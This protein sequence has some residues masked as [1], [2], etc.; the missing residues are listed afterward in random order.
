MRLFSIFLAISFCSGYA[1]A[2]QASNDVPDYKARQ[3]PSYYLQ[4]VLQDLPLSW[5][6]AVAPNNELWISHR[7]GNISRVKQTAKESDSAKYDVQML[8]FAPD[9]LLIGGQGGLLDIIFHPDYAES[10]WVYVSYSAGTNSANSLKIV[11]FKVI[12]NQV[13]QIENVFAVANKKNTPVH[14]GGRL[15]FAQ[16]NALLVATGDGFDYRE[17]AQVKDNQMGK[18]LR[19]TDTG[20][21][22]PLNP[23]FADG[24]GNAAYVMSLGHR[25]P[26]GLLVTSDQT[27]IAHEHGPAGGDEIN[28]IESGVNYGW[29]VI[30][31]GKDY[32]GASISPFTSY[33]GMQQPNLDWTPSIAPSG[34]TYY[35]DISVPGLQNTLLISS[36]KFQQ[37]Y[38]VPFVNGVFG[39]DTGLLTEPKAR[40]RDIESDLAGNVWVLGDGEP[41]ELF[42]LQAK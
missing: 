5:A 14:Y 13:T 28:I 27:V 9:D 37:I 25:N 39:Q 29:P 12:D 4:S 11:R 42:K 10:P 16:G 15:A 7:H 38:A 23:F 32:S 17:Q 1:S 33:A 24:N 3:A 30:T 26:Q 31:N 19:M 18:V 21:P 22:H 35:T 40:L 34:M 2:Q 20:L 41:A 8:E 36:L 6:L